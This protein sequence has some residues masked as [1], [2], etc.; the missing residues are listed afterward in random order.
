M[1]ED[2]CILTSTSHIFWGPGNYLALLLPKVLPLPDE[3]DTANPFIL[4][5]CFSLSKRMNIW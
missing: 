2:K 5:V 1:S 3:K 4:Q